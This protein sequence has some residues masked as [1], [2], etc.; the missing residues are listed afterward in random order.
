MTH[1]YQPQWRIYIR[2]KISVYINIVK[3]KSRKRI[4]DHYFYTKP[5]NKKRT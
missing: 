4:V 3:V 2:Q 1:L 5:K